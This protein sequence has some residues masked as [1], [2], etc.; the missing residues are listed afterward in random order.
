[1]L[2]KTDFLEYLVCP[3]HLWAKKHGQIELE[4]S[5]FDQHLMAQGNEIQ[6][7]AYSFLEE[8]L[9]EQGDVGF[10]VTYRD[11]DFQVRVDGLLYDPDEEVIDIYEVKS[12]NSIK[13]EN[14][15]D[16]TFQRLVCEAS[17][18]VRDV[19]LVYVNG[20]YV[21]G[22]NI[23]LEDFFLIENLNEE[24]KKRREEVLFERER[25]LVVAVQEDPSGIPGCH[26]PQTCP[27]PQLCH[28]ELPAYP[29]FNLPRLSYNKAME[30]KESGVTSIREIPADY[31]LSDKQE[32]HKEAVALGQPLIDQ[33]A[34]R[35]E[36]EGLEYPLFFLDYETYPPCVPLYPGY[37][38]YQH[39]V[40]QYSLHLIMDPEGDLKQHELLITGKEDPGPELVPHLLERIGESGSILVWNKTFETGKNRAM[41]ERYPEYSAGLLEVNERIY[42]LME[43][44][45][46]GF[47]VDQDF[48]GS[49]SLKAVLPVLVPEFK[50]AYEEL[51]ISGGDQ[52]MLI[53]KQI[54]DGK[55]PEDQLSQIRDDL[56][57][58]CRLDTLAMVR[59]WER[60]WEEINQTGSSLREGPG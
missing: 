14:Y 38:P 43:I 28:G 50:N 9:A 2:S 41:A 37:R 23:K 40:F 47:Y 17:T 5:L 25:A 45:S 26:K 7:L 10:E 39:V 20:N 33:A 55:I 31:E 27:S 36:L 6:Q 11:G 4:P 52:A 8:H 34:I 19:Y 58:Y 29:I 30:L 53:W 49:A 46:K 48:R 13:K 42:D 32:L 21:R 59:I 12:S 15:Y 44:F 3:L 60:M 16:V 54:I 57:A 51:P 56:L 24:V 22:D 35:G 18:E 1:M